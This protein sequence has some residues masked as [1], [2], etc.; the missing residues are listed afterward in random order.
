MFFYPSSI[1]LHII[2]YDIPHWYFPED[3]LFDSVQVSLND[4]LQKLTC[5]NFREIG[6]GGI[7]FLFVAVFH[8]PSRFPL[9][10]EDVFPFL[11]W[12]VEKL[13]SKV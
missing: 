10:Q 6:G 7:F 8:S 12:K 1:S 9:Y 4:K 13:I 11:I 3:I 2:H 5:E